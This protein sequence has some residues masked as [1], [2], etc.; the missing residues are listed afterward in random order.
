MTRIVLLACVLLVSGCGGGPLSLLT[1]GGPK[2]AANVQAGKTNTQ[3][4]GQ[5]TVAEQRVSTETVATIE[6]STGSTSVRTE[7]VEQITV[8]ETDKWTLALLMLFA[9][10]VIPSPSEIVRM[11]GSGYKRIFKRK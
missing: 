6:Q 2:V 1:G 10:F 4:I 3:T 7:R 11:I 5:T 9:G 8:N